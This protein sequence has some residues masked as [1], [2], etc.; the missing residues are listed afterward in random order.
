[1]R[2]FW[3]SCL[4]ALCIAAPVCGTAVF[5]AEEKTETSGSAVLEDGVYSAEFDTDSS[6]FHVNEAMEGRG[7]LTV[8]DGEMTIHVTLVS[9]SILN[10]FCG[11]AEDAQ[12]VGAEILEPTED[13]VTYSDGW[14]ETVYGFD[15]PVPALDEEFDVALIGKKGKWYDHK[16]SV[17]DPQPL[18]EGADAAESSTDNAEADADSDNAEAEDAEKTTMES[19]NLE[20]GTYTVEAS[21]NGG[22]GRAEITTPASLTVKEGKAELTVEWSSPYYDYMLV[23]EEKYEPVS[24]EGNSV[25]VIPVDSFDWEM[26]VTA[27]TIAMSTPHEIDYTLYL[28]SKT[29]EETK[30]E[31]NE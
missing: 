2:R 19:L 6:M 9:K 15:I 20:D 11:T 29:I 25:F 7:T 5:A 24:T 14:Q 28:D 4:C 22:T 16:V 1:M 27:D 12:K 26:P 10:L 18:E 31:A 13:P 21:L 30:E 8:E 23:E 17:S 3:I